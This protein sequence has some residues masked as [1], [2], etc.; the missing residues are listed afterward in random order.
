MK[1][2]CDAHSAPQILIS[3]KSH[4]PAA[5]SSTTGA[6]QHHLENT[7]CIP[8][9]AGQPMPAG[10][11]LP[12]KVISSSSGCVSQTTSFP[13]VETLPF[14][15]PRGSLAFA[16]MQMTKHRPCDGSITGLDHASADR[17]RRCLGNQPVPALS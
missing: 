3:T 12:R 11:I 9:F 5:A 4:L 2:L 17:W 15:Y 7:Q 1:P 14:A 8:S 10:H 16:Q 13:G 6:H